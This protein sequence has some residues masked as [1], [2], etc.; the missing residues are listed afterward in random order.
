V[1]LLN[2]LLIFSAAGGQGP[3]LGILRLRCPFSRFSPQES[4]AFRSNQDRVKQ[5]WTLTEPFLKKKTSI[6]T[7][8]TFSLQKIQLSFFPLGFKQQSSRKEPYQN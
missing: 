1:S 6:S 5:H 8:G 3:S 4:S 7:I 2:T